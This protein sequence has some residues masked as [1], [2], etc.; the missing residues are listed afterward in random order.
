MKSNCCIVTHDLVHCFKKDKEEEAEDDN[1]DQKPASHSVDI[2]RINPRGCQWEQQEHPQH[3]ADDEQ[4]DQLGASGLGVTHHFV[5]GRETHVV[6]ESVS[7]HWSHQVPW[8]WKEEHLTVLNHHPC[9]HVHTPPDTVQPF[10]L[11]KSKATSKSTSSHDSVLKFSLPVVT[12]TFFSFLPSV[13]T[14]C[15]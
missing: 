14:C 1:N 9:M 5:E 15:F 11:S 10:L 2:V 8:K 7:Y 3:K 4:H 13:I 12:C 6:A